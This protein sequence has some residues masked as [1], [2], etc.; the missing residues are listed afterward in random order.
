MVPALRTDF[1][2]SSYNK[3]INLNNGSIPDVYSNQAEIQLSEFV[4]RKLLTGAY[5]FK[6][7]HLKREVTRDKKV[8]KLKIRRFCS[9]WL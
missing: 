9:K 6:Q 1:F 3:Y 7:M 8:A 4:S 2:N 5:S